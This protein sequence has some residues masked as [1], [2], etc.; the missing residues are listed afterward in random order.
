MPEETE[1]IEASATETVTETETLGEAG[2]KALDAFKERA[3]VAEKEA[4]RAKQLDAEIAKL[5]EQT[6]SDSE[7]AIAA[8]KAEGITEERARSNQLL[9]RA[10]VKAAAA[11]KLRVADD[12]LRFLDIS[13]FTVGDDGTVDVKAIDRAIEGLITERP[14]LA[15]QASGWGSADGGGR[16]ASLAGGDGDMNALIRRSAGR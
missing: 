15:G 10:E 1:T 6:Q 2:Q 9:L 7:K 13:D 11:G 3:R 5:R 8:A 4:K 16:G 14:D 12:A